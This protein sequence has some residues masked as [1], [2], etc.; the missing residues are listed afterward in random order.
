VAFPTANFRFFYNALAFSTISFHADLPFDKGEWPLNC[1]A[2]FHMFAGVGD[3]NIGNRTGGTQLSLPSRPWGCVD[4][5]TT[6]LPISASIIIAIKKIT[7]S[8]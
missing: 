2:E 7:F 6:F 8:S 5:E 4:Q 1:G 3:Q